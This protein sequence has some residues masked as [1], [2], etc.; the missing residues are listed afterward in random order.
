MVFTGGGKT[1]KPL[2]VMDK[3]ARKKEKEAAKKVVKEEKPS[4]KTQVELGLSEQLVR[5]AAKVVSDS[6][7]ATPSL[8]ASA[9]G[10]KVSVARAL[11]REVVKSGEAVLV[12][13]YRGFLLAKSSRS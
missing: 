3:E 1:K 4:K 9:L 12:A 5:R 2:S 11:L 13:K 6:K 7:I 8:L 10:V